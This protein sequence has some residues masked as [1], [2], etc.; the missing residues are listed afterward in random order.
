MDLDKV[1]I[2]STI[3]TVVLIY[4]IIVLYSIYHYRDDFYQVFCKKKTN[5]LVDDKNEKKLE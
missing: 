3:I 5:T 1:N 4:L 2:Y